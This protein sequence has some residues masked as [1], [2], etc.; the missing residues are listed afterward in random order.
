MVKKAGTAISN[1]V[2]SIFPNEETI[3]TPTIIKAGAV[4]ADVITDKTGKKKRDKR[5]NPAV[6]N[7]AK[8]VFAPDATPADD[9]M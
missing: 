8:P 9:S 6:T 1:R 7:D 4:T 5:K 2:Q 3:N